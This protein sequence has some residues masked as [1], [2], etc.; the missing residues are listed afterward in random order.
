MSNAEAWERAASRY[1]EQFDPPAGTV[2]YGPG[3]P[4]DTQLRLVPHG[5]NGKRVLELGCGAGQAATGFA[6]LGARTIAVDSSP[7]QLAAARRVADRAGVKI[8]FHLGDLCDLAFVPAESIEFVFCAATLDYVED[9][10]RAFRS[11]HR[12][13]RVGGAFVF[14]L[15]HPLVHCLEGGRSYADPLP[16]KVERYGEA[17]LVHP[18]TMGEVVGL[19]ARTGFRLDALAEPVPPGVTLPAAAVWRARKDG[20]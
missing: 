16:V 18:R 11:V 6:A 15:E 8:D 9:L 3:L 20:R 5:L 2:H 4:D 19:V 1:Q 10:G 7:E 17:F 13:L 12:V 14:T